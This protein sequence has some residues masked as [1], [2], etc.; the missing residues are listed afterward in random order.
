MRIA[1]Y[2]FA[3][4]V[5]APLVLPLACG[6]GTPEPKNEEEANSE[7]KSDTKS[8]KADDTAPADSSEK[9]GGDKDAPP[10]DSAAPA[11]SA[12]PAGGGDDIKAPKADDPWMAAH[13]MPDADVNKTV[14]KAKPTLTAC[15]KKGKKKDPSTS[16]EVKV[17][18][19]VT[20][21]GKVTDWKDD[22]SSMSNQDVISCVG[23][24]IKKLKFP[25]Q[26]SPGSAVGSYSINFNP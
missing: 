18:F 2:L 13:T 26:K 23:E 24:A 14:K 4:I 22:S 9:A 21:D 12:A 15:Y 10:A 20:N 1:G 7:T 3:L 16:G 6:G 17:K 11:A 5:S 19:I 8:A 25:K